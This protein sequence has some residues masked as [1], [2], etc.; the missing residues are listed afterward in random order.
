[1]YTNPNQRIDHLRVG[2][3]LIAYRLQIVPFGCTRLKSTHVSFLDLDAGQ[4]FELQNFEKLF[5]LRGD[6]IAVCVDPAWI[7]DDTGE[8]VVLLPGIWRVVAD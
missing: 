3:C 5:D 1:M 6:V 8:R 2:G 4:Q 7:I